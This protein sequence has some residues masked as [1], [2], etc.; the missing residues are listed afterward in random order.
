M[1][2]EF[3]D[4][5]C[6]RAY[7]DHATDVYRVAFGMLRDPDDALDATH[8]SFA[9]AWERWELYD[10]RRPIKPW[11]FGICVHV[12]LDQLRRRRVR[13][14]FASEVMRLPVADAHADPQS[15]LAERQVVEQAMARLKPE[16]R[17]ALVLRHYYGYDYAQIGE[18]LGKPAG[19][20]GSLLTRA[21]ATLRE[22]LGDAGGGA[23]DQPTDSPIPLNQPEPARDARR[24]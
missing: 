1:K 12:C 15:D 10:A 18:L 9:R 24:Q 2:A 22:R 14:L 6:D 8:D 13:R 21:H 17:A 20:V 19:T 4:A 3:R 11:L 7:R 23:A 5:A 16:V